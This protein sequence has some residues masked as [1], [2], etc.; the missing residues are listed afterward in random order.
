MSR[1]VGPITA[2][3][4]VRLVCGPFAPSRAHA[5]STTNPHRAPMHAA[6]LALLSKPDHA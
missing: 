4:Q 1:L 3:E 5:L 6:L 2:C